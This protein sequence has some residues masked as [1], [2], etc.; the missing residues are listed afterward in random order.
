L[1]AHI[2]SLLLADRLDKPGWAGG[3]DLTLSLVTDR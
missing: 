2:L 3:G 1:L